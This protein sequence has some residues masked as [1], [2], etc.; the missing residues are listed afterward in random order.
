MGDSINIYSEGKY[1]INMIKL[2]NVEF[3]FLKTL[4]A[5]QTYFCKHSKSISGN[6]IHLYVSH[7]CIS[8]NTFS[9]HVTSTLNTEIRIPIS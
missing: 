1:P 8:G 2:N 7:T 6:E 9:N 3:F 4:I 5:V